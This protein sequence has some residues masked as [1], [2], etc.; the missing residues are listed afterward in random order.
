MKG[1]LLDSLVSM[2]E[3]TVVAS[4]NRVVLGLFND[5]TGESDEL[6]SW[7]LESVIV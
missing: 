7:C 1:D 2:G 6:R 4:T 3:C 5:E